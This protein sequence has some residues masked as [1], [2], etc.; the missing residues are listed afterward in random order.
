MPFTIRVESPS[1]FPMDVI[2][3]ETVVGEEGVIRPP[4]D[5]FLPAGRF[6]VVV[7]SVEDSA[8][9]SVRQVKAANAAL[10]LGRASLGYATG[11]D[12]EAIDADLARE[13]GDD[14]EPNSP[15]GQS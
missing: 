13:Y 9:P 8:K 1:E 15:N 3:F 11:A 7:R 10:P 2:A 4:A 12:N 14:H 6:E 5:V